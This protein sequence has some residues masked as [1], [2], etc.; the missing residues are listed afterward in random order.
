MLTG[1]RI[2]FEEASLKSKGLHA[3][4]S[5]SPSSTDIAQAVAAPS[6]RILALA[7]LS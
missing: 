5:N 6:P 3:I 2:I 7:G 1:N 4:A